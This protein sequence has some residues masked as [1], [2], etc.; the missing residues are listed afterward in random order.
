M[1]M[2]IP[3]S[4]DNNEQYA[5][6]RKDSSE[7]TDVE[8]VVTSFAS[9]ARAGRRNALPDIQSSAATGGTSDLPAKLEALS[10]KE[11]VKKKDEETTQV[12]VENPPNEEK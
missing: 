12:Q 4:Q 8:S 5:A 11:D 1:V 3:S 7:M 6:M 2:D 9:S 10:M